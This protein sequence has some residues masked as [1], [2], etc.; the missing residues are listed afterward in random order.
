MNKILTKEEFFNYYY[1]NNKLPQPLINWGNKKPFTEMQ[2]NTKYKEYLRK[3]EPKEFIANEHNI[4]VIEACNLCH[5]NNDK[6]IFYNFYNRCSV[7]EKLIL[8][9]K[10]KGYLGEKWDAAHIISRS[11]SS[12]LASKIENLVLLPHLIHL[13][14]DNYINPKNNKRMDKEEHDNLWI[15][16]IGIDRWNQLQ[17][18]TKKY[19]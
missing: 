16:I 5:Q 7:N 19:E 14:I 1:E 2:L 10:M 15:E 18:E 12:N 6:S 13:N 4:K 3:V 9:S 8:S 11:E 17:K